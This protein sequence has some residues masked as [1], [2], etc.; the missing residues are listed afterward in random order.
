MY[1]FVSKKLNIAV[2]IY[3]AD[4][5]IKNYWAKFNVIYS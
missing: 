1:Q 3:G 4:L 5:R 2:N